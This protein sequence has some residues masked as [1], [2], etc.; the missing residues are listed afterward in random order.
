MSI[1]LRVICGLVAALLLAG[2]LMYAEHYRQEVRRM[3]E[4]LTNA[5]AVI[6]GR[7]LVLDKY[8]T[9]AG[10]NAEVISD[11]QNSM[12]EISAAMSKRQARIADL[13]RQNAELRRWSDTR[14]PD[15]VRRMH[16]RPAITGSAGFKSWLSSSSAV[17]A[18]GE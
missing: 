16:Q 18:A 15:A 6:A 3:E 4:E 9:Q 7:D 13:E 14:L 17:P 8:R 5:Q 2:L 12:S 10:I 1:Q 11:Q